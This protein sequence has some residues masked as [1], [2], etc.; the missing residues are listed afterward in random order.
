MTTPGE[1]A[2]DA[3]EP[4]IAEDAVDQAERPAERSEADPAPDLSD[5]APEPPEPPPITDIPGEPSEAVVKTWSKEAATWRTKFRQAEAE[6]DTLREQLTDLHRQSIADRFDVPLDEVIGD[7]VETM[8]LAAKTFSERVQAA[9]DKR[10]EALLKARG[11]GPA[12]PTAKMTDNP[13]A[14]GG[15]AAPPR[16]FGQFLKGTDPDPA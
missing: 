3:G 6:R 9:S 5:D 16:T 10:V 8:T 12:A 1:S 4:D 7:T 15:S 13:S 14:P 2:P 11:I